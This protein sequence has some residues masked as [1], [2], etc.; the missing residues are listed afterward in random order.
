MKEKLKGLYIQ[1]IAK[2]LN[3]TRNAVDIPVIFHFMGSERIGGQ[4]AGFFGT[5][6]SC[7]SL[8]NLWGK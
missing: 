1:H 2:L 4:A 8:Y 3:I 5:I 6:S 7:I